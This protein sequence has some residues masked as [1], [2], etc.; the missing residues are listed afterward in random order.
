MASERMSWAELKRRRATDPGVREGYERSRR[1][2]E[3]G[4]QVRELRLARGS[5]QSALGALAGT[6]QQAIARIESG[7]VTD[8]ATTSFTHICS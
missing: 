3:L 1:A 4:E 8:L 6:S 7:G 2:Y 5:G